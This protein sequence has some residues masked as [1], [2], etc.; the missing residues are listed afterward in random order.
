MN[1]PFIDLKREYH[2]HKQDILNA[3]TDVLE[4]TQFIN[5]EAVGQLEKTLASYVGVKEAIGMS[6]G[7]DAIIACLLAYGVGPGDEVITTPFSFFATVETVMLTGATPVMVD[8]DP[9]TYNISPEKVRA[10]VTS[11]TKGIIAVSL[12]GQC[13]DADAVNTVAEE[14]GLFVHEDACQSFGA[15]YKKQKSG[16]LSHSASTSFFPTKPLGCYGDGGM[17]FTDDELFAAKLRSV[18]NHGQSARYRHDRLGFNGRL[19]TLQAAILLVKFKY[20]DQTVEA[21]R[22]TGTYYTECLQNVVTTPVVKPEQTSVYAQ[23]SVRH[24]KRDRMVAFL[25]EQGVPTAIHYP[26]P[27][28]QQPALAGVTPPFP[29]P[30]AEAAAA[31]I[32]SLPMSPDITREEQDRVIEA[33][34]RFPG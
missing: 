11:R 27:I 10:A 25:K 32:F 6:S 17:V 33:V 13:Y 14:H 7:T 9:E 21:R 4:S 12:F 24:P 2:A 23:Y 8:I 5:G 22:D 30:E 15:E 31:N 26:V 28:H 19:D 29:L 20:F 3:V 34:R 18:R 1:I 16:S